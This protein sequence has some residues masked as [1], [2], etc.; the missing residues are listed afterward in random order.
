M[1]REPLGVVLL[2]GFAVYWG[3][4]I[5]GPANEATNSS[6]SDGV[7][8]A[9]R[10]QSTPLSIVGLVVASVLSSGL[11]WQLI[12]N[13]DK[14][15]FGVSM[16]LGMIAFM[17]FILLV[18]PRHFLMILTIAVLTIGVGGLVGKCHSGRDPSEMYYRY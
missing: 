15:P 1:L 3:F 16:G 7:A 18:K 17:G 8:P 12:K 14:S 11:T 13:F 4:V 10:K 6:Q 5:F 2:I 9:R